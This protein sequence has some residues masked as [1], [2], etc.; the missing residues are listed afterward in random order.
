MRLQTMITHRHQFCA[1][2]LALIEPNLQLDVDVSVASIQAFRFIV[3]TGV[4]SVLHSQNM[5]PF[6]ISAICACFPGVLLHPGIRAILP[7]AA[8]AEHQDL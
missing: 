2:V 1:S 3:Q 6:S 4:E 7:R 8:A 5:K